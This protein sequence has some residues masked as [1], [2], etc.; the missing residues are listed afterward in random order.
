[1]ARRLLS[2]RD[3]QRKAALAELTEQ[4]RLLRAQ[5]QRVAAAKRAVDALNRCNSC[6]A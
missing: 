6:G 1:M 4:Q 3:R 5:R 2:D